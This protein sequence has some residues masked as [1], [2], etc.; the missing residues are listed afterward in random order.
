M[1]IVIYGVGSPMVAD[2]AETCA[3]LKLEVAGW[4]KNV[5]APVYVPA[6]ATVTVPSDTWADLLKHA[7]VVPQ[8]T[9]GQ[10]RVALNDAVGHGFVR[11]ATL[12]DPTAVVASS[13]EIG[14]GSYVNSLAN[15]GAVSRI[16]QFTF[17]NRG[18]SIGHH[19]ELAEFTSIGP[20]AV[21]AAGVR[22][23]RGAVVGAGSVILPGI[24][25]GANAVI[26]A[27]ANVTRNVPPHTIV[28]GNPAKITRT[29]IP[30]YNGYAI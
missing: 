7:F 4:I 15:I 25:I 28:M 20:G 3:R 21:L 16:G 8:F 11:P 18:A 17:I 2:V 5:D 23:D 26:G 14:P 27:G 13:T 29:D 1:P 6:G 12:I 24:E 10:R 19:C 22:I 30:G 9:P